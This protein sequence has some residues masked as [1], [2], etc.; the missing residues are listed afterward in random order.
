MAAHSSILA[1]R[2]HWT[3]EP[4]GLQAMGS[5]RAGHGWARGIVGVLT[6]DSRG[7]MFK[8]V[9]TPAWGSR[10]RPGIPLTECRGSREWG[11]WRQPE[12]YWSPPLRS[13]QT[14][15]SGR[16]ERQRNRRIPGKRM[17]GNEGQED[18]G[19]KHR[20]EAVP[21]ARPQRLLQSHSEW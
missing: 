9:W 20:M 4:G 2:I 21:R 15:G 13:T 10:G 5:R 3:E 1:W 6:Q 18:N 7:E 8:R 17:S 14:E 19:G 12:A 16:T 11:G